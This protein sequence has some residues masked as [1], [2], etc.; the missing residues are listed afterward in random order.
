MSMRLEFVRLASAPGANIQA[1]CLAYKISRKTGYKWLKRFTEE[2]GAG[3][4][5]RS[6]RP[7]CSPTR[8]NDE[9]EANVLRLHDAYD[10]WGGRKLQALLPQDASLP[11]HSTIDAILRRHGRQVHGSMKGP[12][13]A[14]KR[15]EH[16]E[17]NMLWQMDFKGHFPLSD[18]RAGRCHPLTVLD[19]HSR[20]NLCLA[21]CRNEQTSTVKAA[22]TKTF[23]RYGL[24]DRITADNGPPWGLPRGIGI[25]TLEAWLI[26]LGIRVGH[27]RPYHPQ[28][29]GKDERF[30]RT[31]K[32]EVISRRGFQTIAD[33]QAAFDDWREVYNHVRPHRAL[34]H[35]T[36][37]HR[38]RR[39]GREFPRLLPAIEYLSD[40]R[41]LK[42]RGNGH[43]MI[44]RHEC[45]IGEG[46]I[47]HEVALRATDVDGV[48]KIYFCDR[49]IREFD[50]TEIG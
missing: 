28:T 12:N 23:E 30:H 49:E 10:C 22:L 45:Y 9:L 40:D 2:G 44:K 18:K 7:H 26:R 21:A 14:T 5:D 42:V 41:V 38:Y 17:P 3:L 27:S 25:S 20:F 50:M 33:C 1:L 15:F 13:A 24:P 29:Q 34:D 11:H 47:G 39:S 48:F 31:L 19:D 43:V 46:L 4:V 16:A 35:E 6:R 36:P 8:S 37:M 32:L